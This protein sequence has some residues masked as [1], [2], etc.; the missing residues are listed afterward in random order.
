MKCPMRQ[1]LDL[2]ILEEACIARPETCTSAAIAFLMRI[3]H[4]EGTQHGIISSQSR[5]DGVAYF[6]TFRKIRSTSTVDLRYNKSTKNHCDY[7]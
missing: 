1:W 5:S 2:G 7:F 3:N 4:D 6:M